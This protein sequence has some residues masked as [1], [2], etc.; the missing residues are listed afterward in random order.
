MRAPQVPAPSG[1][2]L[3]LSQHQSLTVIRWIVFDDQTATAVDQRRG[4]GT[5]QIQ[6]GDALRVALS[7]TT[8]GIIVL[9]TSGAGKAV[10]ARFRPAP[11][12]S[13]GSRAAF[14]LEPSG[15]LGLSDVPVFLDDSPPEPAKIKM[16]ATRKE[17]L[18]WSSLNASAFEACEAT[19]F[20]DA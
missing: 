20:P 2:R 7:L 15:F 8:P 3:A 18:S 13:A 10:L 12:R 17:G 6:T 11:Q 5:A 4:P 9:P 19:Y 1:Q 14:T 16:V